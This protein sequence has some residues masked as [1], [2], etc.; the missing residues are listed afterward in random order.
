MGI[1]T[2]SIVVTGGAGFVGSWLVSALLERA[3]AARIVVLDN[4]CNGRRDNL[5][6]SPRVS[7]RPIDLTDGGAVLQAIRQERPGLVFHLA[8]LHYIPYCDAH[9][10]Q[11]LE[12]NVVGTQHL[13]DACREHE[14]DRLVLV[15]TVAVYPIREGPNAEDDPAGP[16][17]VYGLSKWTAEKQ[18]ELFSRRARTRCVVARLSNVFGPRETNPHVIPEILDQMLA[19]RHEIALGNVKPKR[20]YIYVSDVARGLLAVAEGATRP[21]R[22]YNVGTG[23]EHSVEEI[24]AHLAAVSGRPLRVA[25]DPARV[26]PSDRMHLLCDLT[27]TGGELGWRPE[28]TLASGLDALWRSVASAPSRREAP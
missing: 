6:D 7:L 25:V 8:A 4:L 12:V 11:T 22:V 17:D 27:R 21:Y 5:P 15:S 1:Q 16:V 23:Q 24:V 18:L 20:D 28:H 13:L 26:R 9:P 10:A 3:E 14:P 19:G 2:D